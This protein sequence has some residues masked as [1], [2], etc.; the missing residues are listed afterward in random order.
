[1]KNAYKLKDVVKVMVEGP[2]G[3]TDTRTKGNIEVVCAIEDGDY[4][5]SDG[6][7][8]SPE[9]IRLATGEEIVSKLKKLLY[10]EPII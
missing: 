3:T 10:R 4:F 9:E 7:W 1:M 2:A 6:Y 8:Y 5:L